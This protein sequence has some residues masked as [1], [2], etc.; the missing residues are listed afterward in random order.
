MAGSGVE[1]G[2]DGFK[3]NRDLSRCMGTIDDGG[4]PGIPGPPADGFDR[5][6]QGCWA[7]DMADKDHPGPRSDSLPESLHK[8]R[9]I[10]ERQGNRLVTIACPGLF[11]G[12]LPGAVHMRRIRGRWS[13]FHPRA[14][15]S[16]ALQSGPDCG[17]PY[18]GQC[19]GWE[20]RSLRLRSRPGILPGNGVPA[21]SGQ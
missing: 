19:L 5:K 16:V 14:L 1:I 12:K 9:L 11:A 10:I 4:D 6:M 7:G 21:P 3:V 8:I 13:G 2:G 17:P 15:R 18:S 20:S